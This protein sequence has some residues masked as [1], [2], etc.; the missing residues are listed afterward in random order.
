[1]LRGQADRARL[2]G[3]LAE[4]GRGTPGTYVLA[5]R[6]EAP[7]EVIVGARGAFRLPSGYYLYVGGALNGLSGRLQR[8]LRPDAKKL[9]WHIDYLRAE[10][11]LVDVWWTLADERLECDWAVALGELPGV[12]EAIPRFGSG[13]C[14]CSTHLFHTSRR[15]P[16]EIFARQW[17]AR[18]IRRLDPSSGGGHAMRGPQ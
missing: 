10:A 8:H 9:Y 17:P 7:K 5:M 15:P 4:L 16:F 3:S 14:R 2:P 13:D 11:V 6:L 1:V 12:G 18:E